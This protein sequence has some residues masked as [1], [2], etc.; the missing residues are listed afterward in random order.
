MLRAD[1]AVV[2]GRVEQAHTQLDSMEEYL[3]S[4]HRRLRSMRANLAL[5][6]S[7]DVLLNEALRK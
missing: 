4:A 6:E 3:K 7:P 2:I 1:I 5:M